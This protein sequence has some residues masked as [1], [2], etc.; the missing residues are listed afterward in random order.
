MTPVAG[1]S[2][3]ARARAKGPGKLAQD[4]H[5]VELRQIQVVRY[6]RV[7]AREAHSSHLANAIE[8]D[9]SGRHQI[10]QSSVAR[11]AAGEAAPPERPAQGHQD[12]VVDL[13]SVFASE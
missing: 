8:A 6:F 7:R 12:R 11:V 3:A 10:A 9:L 4:P 13:A 1:L 5:S 2:G